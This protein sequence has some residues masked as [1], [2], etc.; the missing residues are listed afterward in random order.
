MKIAA[1]VAAR[2]GSERVV[3]K[4]TRAFAGSS[5]LEIKLAQLV[6]LG[7]LDEIAVSSDDNTI[8]EIATSYGCTALRRP[9]HLASSAAPMSDVYRYMAEEI[10]TDVVV[11]ANCTSPLVRDATIEAIVESF[12]RLDAHHDSINTASPIR[13]FLLLDGLPLNYDPNNQPR[14]QDLPDIKA[15]NFAVNVLHRDTMME[16]RNVLG[17]SPMIHVLDEIEGVDIDTPVDFDL[18]EFLYMS[19]GGESYL[20]AT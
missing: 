13:E 2:G 14:S 1:L 17:S 4:N 19:N 10:N 7:P 11:Y 15:L 12:L 20:R 8:L 3:G 9:A 6:R 5:L 16:R 18:A